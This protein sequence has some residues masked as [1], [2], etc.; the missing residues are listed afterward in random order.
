MEQWYVS[1]PTGNTDGPFST[2]K[3]VLHIRRGRVDRESKVCSASGSV[4]VPLADVPEFERALRRSPTIVTPRP[5]SLPTSSAQNAP[6]AAAPPKPAPPL[7]PVSPPP[8][9]PEPRP[10]APLSGSDASGPAPSKP[11]MQ[12]PGAGPPSAGTSPELGQLWE[13]AQSMSELQIVYYVLA[14]SGGC[15]LLAGAI[16]IFTGGEWRGLAAMLVGIG[17]LMVAGQIQQSPR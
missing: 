9:P 10:R 4:W 3:L 17:M 16:Y 2:S 14:G 5:A 11:G 6:A 15:L 12:A 13:K 7:P 1:S 8:Q